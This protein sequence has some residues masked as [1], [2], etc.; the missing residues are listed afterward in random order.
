MI[1][2]DQFKI[3][4]FDCYGTLIDW[5]TGIL[6]AIGPVLSN[7]GV[8]I[9]E[10]QLLETYAEI[11]SSIEAGPYHP[12]RKI[13]HQLMVRM[14]ERFGFNPDAVELTTIAD[15]LPYWPPFDDT[16]EALQALKTKY[17]LA[18]ISNVDDDLFE[19][20]KRQLG[21]EFD[22][23]VTAA[24]ACAYKPSFKIFE[25]AFEKIGLPREQILHVAQSLFHDH[26]PAKQLGLSTVWINRRSRKSGAGATPPAE[27]TPDAEFPD[28]ASFVKKVGL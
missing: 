2:F 16:V 11:E 20:S 12:Y 23:V 1:D 18:V 27:A 15:A 5:E 13:L 4:T 28:M 3:L 10:D 26:V 22:F 24:Q 25:Y 21:V 17:Q 6:E 8:A 19:G 9:G 7:R 14:C